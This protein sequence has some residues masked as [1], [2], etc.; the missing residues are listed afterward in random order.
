[1]IWDETKR[2]KN[3][4]KHGLDFI[5]AG[6]RVCGRSPHRFDSDLASWQQTTDHQ[7][8]SCS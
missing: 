4:E 6:L 1:M 2:K 8:S 7:F 5:D 3:I